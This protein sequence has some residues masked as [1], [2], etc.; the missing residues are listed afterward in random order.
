MWAFRPPLLLVLE[1][2]F[3]WSESILLQRSF[4]H[5]P[6]DGSN[7]VCSDL[8]MCPTIKRMELSARF[9]FAALKLTACPAS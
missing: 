2:P 7:H 9:S 6:F 3:T 8:W 5:C 4:V 1:I